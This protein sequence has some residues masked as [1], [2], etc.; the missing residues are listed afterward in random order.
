MTEKAE[1]R[2]FHAI[3]KKDIKKGRV[4]V[5]GG[6]FSVTRHGKGLGV[7]RDEQEIEQAW[8]DGSSPIA[9]CLFDKLSRIKQ[10]AEFI[11]KIRRIVCFAKLHIEKRL[12]SLKFGVDIN[13]RFI[14]VLI[15]NSNLI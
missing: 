1:K 5:K 15:K 4:D 6:V 8:D 14:A 11:S 12:F 2:G 13:L 3:G 7:Q 10:A 9:K